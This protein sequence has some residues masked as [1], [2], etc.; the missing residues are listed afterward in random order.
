MAKVNSEVLHP[1][2]YV[3]RYLKEL[4]MNNREFSFRSN[5]SERTLSDLIS[6][7]G[8]IT[9]DIAYNLSNYFNTTIDYWTNLQNA[10]DVYL[11]QNKLKEEIEEDYQY[12]EPYKDYLL[13]N[14]F[15]DKYEGKID[16][17]NKI[18]KLLSINRLSSL[19]SD[20][21]ISSFK[22]PDIVNDENLIPI[23]L[24]L[25]YALN[26]GRKI[27]AKSYSRRK[28]KKNII[29]LKALTLKDPKEFVPEINNILNECGVSFVLVPY[30]K[31]CP[32]YGF[33]RWLDKK[34]VV[35]AISITSKKADIFWNTFFKELAH[36]LLE[37]KRYLLL[38][39]ED[40]ID[41]EG[42]GLS[43]DI[44]IPNYKWSDFTKL[45]D[46][47]SS[48]IEKFASEINIHPSL[49]VSRL[50]KENIIKTGSTQYKKFSKTY[51]I[52]SFF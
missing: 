32:I 16:L 38:Q 7:K 26:M 19:N 50:E 31:E 3:E 1:G 46:F 52:N 45:R 27:D 48:S 24:Y 28:L 9:F 41:Y 42:D 6:G 37:H 44:L 22:E 39:S 4:K 33:T 29:N 36:V 20:E 30:L 34:K 13:D 2:K 10:Y 35:M 21:L 18:R 8:D 12:I 11:L 14:G 51:K 49:I 25:S 43:D 5:V 17:V 15:I 23:N 47:S 40:S